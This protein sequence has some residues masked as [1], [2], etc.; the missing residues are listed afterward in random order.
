MAS[1]TRMPVTSHVLS[2]DAS[3]PST[4]ILWY[5]RRHDHACAG[6]DPAGEAGASYGHGASF[7]HDG[8]APFLAACSAPA[9]AQMWRRP[10]SQF[11]E[12][13]RKFSQF[14][15]INSL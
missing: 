12:L 9:A 4:S 8:A 2:T 1:T 10:S 11:T 7:W 14:H 15:G 13:K 3:A 5:L 6:G